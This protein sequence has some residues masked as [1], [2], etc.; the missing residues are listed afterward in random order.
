MEY[1]DNNK[2]LL[3]KSLERVVAQMCISCKLGMADWDFNESL[4]SALQLDNCRK[5]ILEL[6][7]KYDETFELAK[8]TNIR[9]N[10]KYKH[11]YH[12]NT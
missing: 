6:I 1:H 5:E 3:E 10:S 7:K 2:L 4:R 12:L 11:L 9:L 8:K